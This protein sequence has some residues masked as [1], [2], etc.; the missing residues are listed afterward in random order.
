MKKTMTHN[1]VFTKIIAMMLVV[2]CAVSTTSLLTTS[3]SAATTEKSDSSGEAKDICAEFLF[4]GARSILDAIS[5]TNPITGIIGKGVL[6]AFRKYYGDSIAETDAGT[7]QILDKLDEISDTISKYHNDEIKKLDSAIMNTQLADFNAK[8][9]ALLGYNKQALEELSSHK[10]SLYTRT[11]YQNI[12]D[13]TI[14]CNNFREYFATLGEYISSCYVSKTPALE[15]H[16]NLLKKNYDNAAV[17]QNDADIF[18]KIVIEQYALAYTSLST[19]YIAKYQLAQLDYKDGKI[20]KQE[21]ADIYDSVTASTRLLF[22]YF[23]NAGKEYNEIKDE[24]VSVNV[25]DVTIDGKTTEFHSFADAWAKALTS[26]SEAKVTL[27]KDIVSDDLSSDVYNYDTYVGKV[28]K[29]GSLNLDNNSY[30]ITVDLNGHSLVNTKNNCYAIYVTDSKLNINDSAK[31]NNKL[32][33][34]DITRSKVN[35]ESINVNGGSDTGINMHESSKVNINNSTI[36]G[37]TNSGIILNGGELTISNSTIKDNKSQNNGG[38]INNAAGG[39]LIINNC[40]IENNIAN[41]KGGGLYTKEDAEINN[42]RIDYNSSSQD[43][44]GI[45]ADYSGYDFTIVVNISNSNINYNSCDRKGGGIYGDS[46]AYLNIS[47]T[48]ISSN[49]A[50]NSGGGLFAQKGDGSSCD[51]R[52]RGRVIIEDNT[53]NGRT[54]NAF[55]EDGVVSKCMFNCEGLSSNSRI[56]VTSDT[57]DKC[58]DIARCTTESTYN[59][60]D[61]VFNSDSSNR[62]MNKYTHW[63]S[64]FYYVEIVKN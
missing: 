53:A 39:N 27:K 33:G 31:A 15:L 7:Q 2:T 9:V 11:A 5:S 50:G 59:G 20:T 23:K 52:I 12:I 30:E 58:L 51:P 19:G 13:N 43:G 54:D 56:G 46:M 55:L 40:N 18:N 60:L 47:D 3:V 64:S 63:Y 28:F 1:K 48:S 8:L 10:S 42:C 25:A 35:L 62:H 49:R 22:S 16:L 61:G 45:C 36:Y 57:S 34:I 17:V 6:G 41:G 32:G 26:N 4:E 44:G 37:Y 14:N 24:L 21:L 38:G 29:N